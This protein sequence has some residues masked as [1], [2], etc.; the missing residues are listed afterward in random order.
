[1]RDIDKIKSYANQMEALEIVKDWIIKSDKPN[2]K[3]NRLAYLISQLVFDI[4]SL[5]YYVDD[6]RFVNEHII[7]KKNKEILKLRVRNGEAK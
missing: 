5:E 2:K 7:D 6:L 4:N 1:M 3:L